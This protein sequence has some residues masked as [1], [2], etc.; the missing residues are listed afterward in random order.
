M[1]SIFGLTVKH[2]KVYTLPIYSS[3]PQTAVPY[4]LHKS[5]LFDSLFKGLNLYFVYQKWSVYY[6]AL[7]VLFFNCQKF[8]LIID[9]RIFT[10]SIFCP[11]FNCSAKRAQI[12]RE[13]AIFGIISKFFFWFFPSFVLKLRK[14]NLF[15][16]HHLFHVKYRN[17][18]TIYL[19][20][21]YGIIIDL[22]NITI[23]RFKGRDCL[24]IVV[25]L[26]VPY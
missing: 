25:E 2:S 7:I 18:F 4:L 26:R 19:Y 5:K 3:A 23:P 6:V 1:F 20:V 15:F 16:I 11:L 14:R 8:R 21:W 9:F 12:A 10:D 13:V 24:G 22:I 17:N